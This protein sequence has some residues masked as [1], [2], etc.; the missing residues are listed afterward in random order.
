METNARDEEKGD[1][2]PVVA[3]DRDNPAK[4]PECARQGKPGAAH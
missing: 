4:L 3:D 1:E 2:K